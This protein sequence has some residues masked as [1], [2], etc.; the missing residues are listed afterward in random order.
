[1]HPYGIR[2]LRDGSIDY[3]FY[4]AR[5]AS[6]RRQSLRDAV[7]AAKTLVRFVPVVIGTVSG[8]LL[9][10]TVA[11]TADHKHAQSAAAELHAPR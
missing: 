7:V 8:L 3:D 5:G 11:S 6:L 4:R 10:L 9:G 2:Q 1:M